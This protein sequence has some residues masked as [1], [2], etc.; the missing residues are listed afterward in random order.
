MA[1]TVPKLKSFTA[2]ALDKAAEKL[3]AAL[4][5]RKPQRSRTKPTGK[6]SATAGWPQER[7]AHEINDLWLKAAP[8]EA[9]REV[10]Q[11][12]NEIKSCVEETVDEAGGRETAR[13]SAASDQNRLSASTSPSPAFAARSAPSI[14]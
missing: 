1:Y 10:G 4:R 14:P 5:Q 9:K 2:A 12:V 11:R 3:L 6:P 13:R 8:K 7:R